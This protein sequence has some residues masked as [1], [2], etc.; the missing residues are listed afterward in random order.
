VARGTGEDRRWRR[1]IQGAGRMA[2]GISRRERVAHGVRVGRAA[3]RRKRS[4]RS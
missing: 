4:R 1:A 3:A 2:R